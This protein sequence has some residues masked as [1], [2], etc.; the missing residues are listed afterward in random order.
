MRSFVIP[1][2]LAVVLT[3][4]LPAPAQEV[5]LKNGD[6]IYA[7]QVSDKGNTIQYEVGDNTYTI[8]RSKVASIEA[9]VRPAPPTVP[10]APVFTPQAQIGGE[11]QLFERIVQNHA[12]DRSTLASLESAGNSRSS[13]IG[14]YIAAKAEFEWGKLADSRR[15]FE[16]ALR[17]DSENP[18]ILNYYAA[19]LVRS[20]NAREAT[21]YAEKAV[22]VAPDSADALA[23]LGY[24]QF[25]SDHGR[26]AIR[27]WKK[28]LALRPDASIQQMVER[29][30][31]ETATEGNYSAREA[32]HF[33]LHYEG[34]QS[35]ESFREELLQ[36]LE[37]DY[38]QLSREFESEPRSAIPVVLYTNQ[39]FFDV[40]RAPSW[41]GALYDG[42]VRIPL[43]GL[44]SV[45]P[46]LAHALRHELTH[47]FIRQL[48]AGRCP[49]WLNEGLAQA[50]E[51]RPLGSRAGRLAQLFK[52]QQEIP[53]NSLESGFTSLTGLE[54]NLAYDESLAAADYLRTRYGMSDL[55][56]LLQR[57]GEGASTQAA[58]RAVLHTDYQHLQGEVR[59]YLSQASGS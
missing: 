33:V 47:A 11:A 19:L 25:A 39:A 32:G 8:P 53:Y 18:T 57:I 50:M 46:E 12:I 13:A 31:R 3:C 34:E 15:D 44:N 4:A 38:Q 56:R 40:T 20:G 35:S 52:G 54:A 55:I 37:Q 28:S 6:V 26:D 14:Y 43:Q 45:T 41:T 29:A 10:Q 27:T 17:Y 2:W 24:A 36:N 42:K 9:G 58:L 5:R 22:S 30:E 23:V 59:E 49:T 51:P 21:V 48:A 16:T 7:D 1:C